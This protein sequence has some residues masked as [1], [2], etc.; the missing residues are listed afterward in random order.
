MASRRPGSTFV[1][2]LLVQ[3]TPAVVSLPFA[4]EEMFSEPTRLSTTSPVAARAGAPA[5]R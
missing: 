3:G 4:T 1:A 2:A 5:G